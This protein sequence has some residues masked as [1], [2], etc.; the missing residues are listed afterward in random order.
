MVASFRD[1]V[2]LWLL[3]V[4]VSLG[5]A[6]SLAMWRWSVEYDTM[7]PLCFSRSECLSAVEHDATL[8]ALSSF[9]VLFVFALVISTALVF[10]AQF[11][12]LGTQANGQV[13]HHSPGEQVQKQPSAA[14]A[15]TSRE[16]A[17]LLHDGVVTEEDHVQKRTG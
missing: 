16:L 13:R 3:S 12:G 17:K 11:F 9:A 4:L 14:V 2:V 5:I 15:E 8:V 7:A 6:G 1:R 10:R